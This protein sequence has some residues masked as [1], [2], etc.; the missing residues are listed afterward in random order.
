MRNLVDVMDQPKLKSSKPSLTTQ[1]PNIKKWK[2]TNPRASKSVD[3]TSKVSF[4]K[5]LFLKFFGKKRVRNRR[6][7]SCPSIPQPQYPISPLIPLS[8]FQQQS[9]KFKKYT[10]AKKPSKRKR[11]HRSLY[12]QDIIST[13]KKLKKERK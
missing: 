5:T 3:Y 9:R 11:Y 12:L 10:Q 4:N 8:L 1:F 13:L 7:N 6:E 2:K